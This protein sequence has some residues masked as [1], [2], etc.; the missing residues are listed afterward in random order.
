[1]IYRF[2]IENQFLVPD[3]KNPTVLFVI[4]PTVEE[5]E[6][7]LNRGIDEHSYNSALDPDELARVETDEDY[8]AIVCKI[9]KAHSSE[10]PLQFAVSSLG[11]FMLNKTVIFICGEEVTEFMHMKVKSH[12]NLILKIMSKIV[13]H[14]REHLRAINMVSDSLQVEINTSIGNQ[15]LISLFSLQKS[16][17]Y[18]LDS[19]NSNGM[20]LSRMQSH[21]MKTD[22]PE[23]EAE[24]L[25]HIQIENAQ[26]CKQ[27]D[28]YSNILS[29]LM[30]ARASIISNNL[31]VLMKTLNVI[32]I[33]IMVPTLVVSIFSMNVPM[34]HNMGHN[35]Y[36]FGGILA[37]AVGCALGF[38]WWLKRKHV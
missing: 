35:G 12:L 6:E 7:L 23:D 21:F 15:H 27:A 2:K 14:F 13:V 31:N 18:Y 25:E 28:I 19:I 34:P 33:A 37:L 16:L 30:D 29:N 38:I 8:F 3:A 4:Q 26:C 9:P 36:S 1:M 22:I 32:T 11:V 10:R 17:V 20:L 24:L 5:K